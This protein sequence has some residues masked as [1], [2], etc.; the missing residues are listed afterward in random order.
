MKDPITEALIFA[1]IPSLVFLACVLYIHRRHV[2]QQ[3]P[4]A[5]ADTAPLVPVFPK[6]SADMDFVIE[7][8]EGRKYRVYFS[9]ERVEMIEDV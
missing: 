3:A 1:L 6:F 7:D 9:V 8:A 5:S 4:V 2:A